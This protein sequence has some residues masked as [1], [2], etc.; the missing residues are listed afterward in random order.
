MSGC[1]LGLQSPCADGGRAPTSALWGSVT[2]SSPSPLPPEAANETA[3][4]SADPSDSALLL[5]VP[6]SHLQIGP[7]LEEIPESGKPARK[8]RS[9]NAGMGAGTR[10]LKPPATCFPAFLS[11]ICYPGNNLP[12][13]SIP[14]GQGHLNESPTYLERQDDSG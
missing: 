14:G 10:R 1:P 6:L 12:K 4:V 5:L 9:N 8:V 2:G 11:Q 7:G 13:I 3:R